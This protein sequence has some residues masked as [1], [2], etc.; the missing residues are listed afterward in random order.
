MIGDVQRAAARTSAFAEVASAHVGRLLRVLGDS[1]TWLPVLQRWG[2]VLAARFADGGRLLACGNG[3]SGAQAQHLTAEF[4]GRFGADRPA[5]SALA[6]D[7]DGVLLSA[8]GND[9]G[10]EAVFARQLDGHGRPGDVLIAL[11]T[12]G[13]SPN[14]IAAVQAAAER[15]L[16][17]W[18]LTG[19]APNPLA[20]AVDEVIAVDAPRP[21][22]VQEVHQVLVHLLVM[23]TEDAAGVREEP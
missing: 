15:G 21:A 20:D 14:L 17:T 2:A 18:A 3:G 11:S 12:S 23:A 1:A 9:Y 4:V 7:S 8:L 5:W 6:L 10:A 13:R 19:P 16:R 22:T